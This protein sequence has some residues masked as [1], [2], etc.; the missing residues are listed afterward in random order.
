MRDNALLQPSYLKASTSYLPHR[1]RGLKQQGLY[2]SKASASELK[3][4]I[5]DQDIRGRTYIL[6]LTSVYD[7]GSMYFSFP[8]LRSWDLGKDSIRQSL[9][10]FFTAAVNGCE[11]IK[12][13]W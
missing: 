11:K 4:K 5:K 6:R 12:L 9:L 13:K 10:I 7:G 8:Q 2:S 1:H 3:G